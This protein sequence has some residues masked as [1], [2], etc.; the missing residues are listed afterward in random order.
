MAAVGVAVEET[1]QAAPRHDDPPAE[2]EGRKLAPG[3]EL[4]G[5]R[6]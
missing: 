4:I 5:V 3:D 6:P 1:L 2:P